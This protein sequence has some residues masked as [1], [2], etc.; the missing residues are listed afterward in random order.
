MRF[1]RWIDFRQATGDFKHAMKPILTTTAGNPTKLFRWPT[2]E[3][4]SPARNYDVTRD[5]QKFLMIKELDGVGSGS[6]RASTSSI[7]MVVNWAE[8]LKDKR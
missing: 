4:P 5:G 1:F 6:P 3:L 8:A 2:L 7:V